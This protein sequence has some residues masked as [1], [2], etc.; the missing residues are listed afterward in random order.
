V[1]LCLLDGISNEA[2]GTFHGYRGS[3]TAVRVRGE[4]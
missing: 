2:L 1:A 3:V 4:R